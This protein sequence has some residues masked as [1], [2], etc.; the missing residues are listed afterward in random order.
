MSL[1][2]RLLMFFGLGPRFIMAEPG[3]DPLNEPELFKRRRRRGFNWFPFA[4]GLLLTAGVWA[5]WW[6]TRLQ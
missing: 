1:R 2:H 3:T 6:F 4:L 5:A